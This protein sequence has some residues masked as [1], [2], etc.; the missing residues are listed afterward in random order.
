VKPLLDALKATGSR[1]VAAW[2]H[3]I[4]E[5]H[6][7]YHLTEEAVNTAK[8]NIKKIGD[9]I[10][11]TEIK[12]ADSAK[13]RATAE[14]AIRNFEEARRHL[15]NIGAL[16]EGE[17]CEDAMRRLQ[18]EIRAGEEKITRL[19]DKETWLKSQILTTK[20]I[21]KEINERIDQHRCDV[22]DNESLIER[23]VAA[24]QRVLQLTILQDIS[25]GELLDLHNAHLRTQV[26]GYRDSV[27]T[28]L[29][30]LGVKDAED[31]RD[32]FSLEKSGLLAP[33]HDV[34]VVMSR[35]RSLGIS[36]ALPAY[37]WL[38]EH[39]LPAGA[40]KQ[41]Q[42]H[43]LVLSGIII[44]NEQDY[45]R[46]QSE[47]DSADIRSPIALIQSPKL[48]NGQG[49]PEVSIV[50]PARL[51]L[52]SKD[53]ANREKS[54]LDGRRAQRGTQSEHYEKVL[55]QAGE[56][57]VQIKAFISEFSVGRMKQVH[58]ELA[59]ARELENLALAE[60]EQVSRQLVDY[61]TQKETIAEQR[62][63]LQTDVQ[64]ARGYSQS[65]TQFHRD[66]DQKIDGH[67]KTASSAR[68]AEEA[69]KLALVDLR[70]KQTDLDGAA[71]RLGAKATCQHTDWKLACK[72]K[73]RLPQQYI[74]E[75]LGPSHERPEEVSP[76]FDA[77]VQEYEGKA[78]LGVIDGKLEAGAKEL[79]R[80]KESFDKAVAGLQFQEV[81]AAATSAQID[82]DL[83]DAQSALEEAKS[84]LLMLEGDLKKA[85]RDATAEA[86]F[87]TGELQLEP[88][89][90]P[91]TSADAFSRGEACINEINRLTDD[92]DA[93]KEKHQ[94]L[95]A[96]KNSLEKDCAS[97]G[98]MAKRYENLVPAASPDSRFSGVSSKDDDITE[99]FS[100][101]RRRVNGDLSAVEKKLAQ[102]FDDEIQP[103]IQ[104]PDL[105]KNR[106][107]FRDTLKRRARADFDAN[108]ADYLSDIR[109]QIAAYQHDLDSEEQELKII[110]GQLDS[111]ARRTA[112]LL[113]QTES[114]SRMPDTLREWAGL[115]FLKI[116]VPKKNDE[117]ERHNLLLQALEGWYE[118]NNIPMGSG[119]AFA[120][121][122]AVCG[123]KSVTVRMLKPEYHLSPVP[124][125]ITDMIKFSDGEKL[126]AAILIYCVLVRLRARARAKSL[127][128]GGDSGMLLLDNPFGKATLAQ[129]VDLQ[130]KMARLN[131]VQLIYATGVN[132]FGALKSFDHIFRL[133]NTSR[134]RA[135]GDYHVTQDLTERTIEGI[136]VGVELGN[137]NSHSKN[138]NRSQAGTESQDR[139]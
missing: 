9:E 86:E 2:N 72:E 40:T 43:P 6:V 62:T 116:V 85:R 91:V 95:T 37:H 24:R 36:S 59:A 16:Q 10:T 122:Y 126:T 83:S 69:A 42:R 81:E 61:E 130:V 57:I 66:H 105:D 13:D 44:Q 5:L 96:T 103:L 49:S 18:S 71:Q 34:D 114:A 50:T 31:E 115:P 92:I 25:Q 68:Q 67:R 70:A 107:P 79:G 63:T 38:A 54:E 52:Y 55:L 88:H 119:L 76:I 60:A 82:H 51:G 30:S 99:D 47:I 87:K 94:Q 138:G 120:C 90:M 32:V 84:K 93:S 78:Q 102:K 129:F 131:G 12:R 98:Q 117:A 123:A 46:A 89:E 136:A 41:L 17:A 133:R 128:I 121:V 134:N 26:E 48:E 75:I 77:Q 4:S 113:G 118:R 39:Q 35:L 19:A 137:G 110:V 56:T 14:A 104:N 111:I 22:K 101:R 108:A 124:H 73:D 109:Q 100:R 8:S 21:L 97:Y 125:E 65:L 15:Q 20:G 80:A 58:E 23:E 45:R 29:I 127:N 1:L 33:S 3:R 64:K 7:A 74:G 112:S 132:D 106:I 11:T 135:S 27:R 53:E 28:E 139:L